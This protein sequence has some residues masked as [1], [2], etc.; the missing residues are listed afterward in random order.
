MIKE[1]NMKSITYVFLA[2][3]ILIASLSGC[4]GVRPEGAMEWMK[5]QPWDTLP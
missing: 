1:I 3:L 4:S 5:R 2:A